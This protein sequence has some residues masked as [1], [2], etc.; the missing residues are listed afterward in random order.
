MLSGINL[1]KCVIASLSYEVRVGRA[2]WEKEASAWRSEAE[3][4][5]RNHPQA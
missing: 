5:P 1:R 4:F 3:C 2:L